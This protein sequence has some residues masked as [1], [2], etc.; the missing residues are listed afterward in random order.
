MLL[1]HDSCYNFVP[2]FHS[3]SNSI[4]ELL[5]HDTHPKMKSSP[6]SLSA[7]LVAW[8]NVKYQEVLWIKWWTCRFSL[9]IRF[10]DKKFLYVLFFSPFYHDCRR[11]KSQTS[12]SICACGVSVWV[13]I[14]AT[15]VFSCSQN[16]RMASLRHIFIV[17]CVPSTK[18]KQLR[19]Y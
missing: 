16:S 9:T 6:S 14:L 5:L 2:T 4:N 17:L 3:L 1:D 10:Y 7:T 13:Y 15:V 12:A 19:W 11:W 8:L 18:I